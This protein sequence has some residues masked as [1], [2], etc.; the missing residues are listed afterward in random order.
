MRRE[1]KKERGREGERG[2]YIVLSNVLGEPGFGRNSVCDG[3][4]CGEGF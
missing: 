2:T 3:L 4:L 1:K